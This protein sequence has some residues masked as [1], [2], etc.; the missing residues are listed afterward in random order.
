MQSPVLYSFR[1]CPYAIRARMALIVA[2]VQYELREVDLKDKQAAMLE[3]SPKGTVP[4]MVFP[5]ATVID[6]SLDIMLWA[7]TQSDVTAWLDP[8]DGRLEEMQAL[9]GRNDSDFK[10]H[11]DRYKY[12]DRYA[13]VPTDPL[14]HRNQACAFLA[15]LEALLDAK[16][17][18][19]GPH[20]SLADIAIFPFVR[21]FAAVDADW[22]AGLDS[23]RLQAWLAGWQ[24]SNLFTIAMQRH[25]AWKNSVD[26]GHL[27]SASI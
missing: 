7:L 25:P 26:P 24:D 17:F 27:L 15:D 8:Q 19:F 1:R 2:G 3:A 20:P 18:L 23:P 12:P 4:V 5:D 13:D 10:H 11:L 6:E 21:Q 14:Q 22:F 16:D 9:I